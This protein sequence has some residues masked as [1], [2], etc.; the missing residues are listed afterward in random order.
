MPMHQNLFYHPLVKAEDN[1]HPSPM[2]NLHAF[3]GARESNPVFYAQGN[4]R[5]EVLV[6]N[7]GSNRNHE[8]INSLASLLQGS[9][10][11]ASPQP[12]NLNELLQ[13]SFSSNN[14][15]SILQS[16]FM[17]SHHSQF[18]GYNPTQSSY[19][20]NIMAPD[21]SNLLTASVLETPIQNSNMFRNPMIQQSAPQSAENMNEALLLKLARLLKQDNGENIKT[22]LSDILHG[23]DTVNI[24]AQDRQR[25]LA[26]Q[27]RPQGDFGQSF[28]QQSNLNIG[29]KTISLSNGVVMNS[30]NRNNECYQTNNRFAPVFVNNGS[31]NANAKRDM[32]V[33]SDPSLKKGNNYSIIPEEDSTMLCDVSFSGA[34]AGSVSMNVQPSSPH[35]NLNTKL[36]SLNINASTQGKLHQLKFLS[37]L[38]YR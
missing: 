3:S 35:Q 37:K 13:K 22:A 29:Q 10:N 5:Q 30:L 15:N 19:V 24:P 4:V 36:N 11:S 25:D 23:Y 2:V 12:R 18:A 26:Y 6:N 8:L 7:F 32:V 16:P 9:H 14:S 27:R 31:E 20:Q 34:K 17:S 1:S 21:Y 33:L 28:H 38:I